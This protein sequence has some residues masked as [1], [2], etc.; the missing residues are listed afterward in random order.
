MRF[1][2]IIGDAWRGLGRNLTTSIAMIL[3]SAIALAM[4]GTGL[5]VAGMAE[6]TKEMWIGR[7][8]I[9]V[10]ID[11][12]AASKDATCS[13][14]Y[15]HDLFEAL[16]K[17][18][19]VQSVRYLSPEQSLELYRATAS[20]GAD[21]EIAQSANN[22]DNSFPGT[23]LVKLGSVNADT[24]NIAE[25]IKPFQLEPIAPDSPII[26]DYS[27]TEPQH[28][29]RGIGDQRLIF[30]RIFSFLDTIRNASFGLAIL[31]A[32]GALFLIANMVQIAAYNRRDT[33]RIMRLVGASRLTTSAPFTLEVVLAAVL[34][35]LASILGLFVVYKT[36]LNPMLGSIWNGGSLARITAT[37]VAATAPI[38]LILAI[39]VSAAASMITLP[40]Y[41][42]R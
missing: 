33:V 11:G 14:S 29:A 35:A 22:E 27:P 7:T 38:L 36:I 31:L 41:V 16:Q 32:V 19:G 15:C 42:K 24:N 5:L 23:I 37:D 6:R 28:I 1:K 26:K 25:T 9:Q 12:G 30:D 21:Q 20:P 2:Y 39:V 17:T 4:F 18:E 13:K 40:F 10:F 8:E 3:T 34:G